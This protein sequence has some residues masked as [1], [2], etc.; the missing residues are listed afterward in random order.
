L[1]L[2]TGDTIWKKR[3]HYDAQSRLILLHYTYDADSLNR[4]RFERWA[5][6]ANGYLVEYKQVKH[7]YDGPDSYAID[8]CRYTTDSRGRIQ[9]RISRSV[10]TLYNPPG[11]SNPIRRSFGTNQDSIIYRDNGS[12]N[13]ETYGF[14][15]SRTGIRS[16]ISH[17]R[18]SYADTLHYIPEENLEFS[19][20]TGAVTNRR[21]LRETA[22][23]FWEGYQR[24]ST[25]SVVWK[26]QIDARQPDFGSQPTGMVYPT[27]QYSDYERFPYPVGFL[28][29]RKIYFRNGALQNIGIASDT[30]VYDANGNFQS[31]AFCFIG[32]TTDTTILPKPIF[33]YSLIDIASQALATLTPAPI[34]VW[35]QQG[36]LSTLGLPKGDWRLDVLSVTGQQVA[37][38][39]P[40]EGGSFSLPSIAE[41]Y[42]LCRFS[43]KD[44]QR[45]ARLVAKK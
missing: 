18:Y 6:D 12:F 4:L 17:S 23:G 3:Y 30:L 26:L 21:K 2:S 45:V 14:G 7:G 44:C 11:S 24:Y 36:R 20:S 25:D 38:G 9:T 29:E 42:Y 31:R 8:S 40:E 35:I 22:S 41:G 13:R 32:N 27:Y 39:I 28:N 34:H 19:P 1:R 43:D 15:Y 33:K 5:Y 10:W 37:S 16:L